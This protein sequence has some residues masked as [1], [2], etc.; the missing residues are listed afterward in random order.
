MT[1]PAPHPDNAP[2]EPGTLELLLAEVAPSGHLD[3]IN[4]WLVEAGAHGLVWSPRKM[5]SVVN[6]E[7]LRT[8]LKLAT[9]VDGDTDLALALIGSP[10]EVATVGHAI[11]LATSAETQ[12][13]YARIEALESGRATLLYGDDGKPCIVDSLDPDPGMNL[14]DDPPPEP[15]GAPTFSTF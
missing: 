15:A 1:G 9:F 14:P 8:A 13:V 11:G 12:A 6:Y 3:T 10:H 5:P 7:R 4:S 2:C